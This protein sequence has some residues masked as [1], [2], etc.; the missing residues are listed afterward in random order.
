MNISELMKGLTGS[1]VEMRGGIPTVVGNNASASQ[2]SGELYPR[3][4][5]FDNTGALVGANQPM[6][7]D[8]PWKPSESP[9]PM[10][11]IPDWLQK[12]LTQAGGIGAGGINPSFGS[13]AR[14]GPSG[15]GYDAN[16]QKM[17]ERERREMLNLLGRERQGLQTPG[18]MQ[19]ATS[20]YNQMA[21]G[22]LQPYSPETINMLLGREYSAAGAAQQR[23]QGQ[24]RQS[25]GARGLLGGGVEQG[26]M[27]RIASQGAQARQEARTNILPQALLQNFMARERGI[28][29]A[30]GFALGAAAARQP[31]VSQEANLRAN[32][33]FMGREPS[34]GSAGGRTA[35][36]GRVGT[37]S[38]NAAPPRLVMR[39]A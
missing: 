25:L 2:R 34:Y 22:K 26:A 3:G 8:N 27:N 21:S 15:M 38:L 5:Y 23:A 6:A 12:Q 29:G 31:Y 20:G 36:T 16:A 11:P 17:A 14:L 37:S 30:G 9:T 33:Q 4:S 35:A 18:L 19:T 1:S 24:T 10:S 28:S 39:K 7:W 13:T 32:T